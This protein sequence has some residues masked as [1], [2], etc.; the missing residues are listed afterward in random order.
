MIPEPAARRYAE[1]AHLIAKEQSREDEW[2]DS[3]RAIA[4][5]FDNADA[6][7]FFANS[8][9]PVD[10]KNKL[11]ENSL[12]G[13]STDIVNFARLLLRR[14]RTRLA[15][16]IAQAY[17]ELLDKE[18]GVVHATV[19]SAVPLSDDELRETTRK[20]EEMT[21]GRV[22]V[23]TEVNESILGGLVVRIGDRLIDGSTRSKLLALKQRLSG[24]T[25]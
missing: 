10:A 25:A 23:E 12:S 17:Q 2:A 21:G 3:L 18:K 14:Q 6:A 19:I 13:L 24:A 22:I 11:L 16:Q 5:L 15:P 8:G 20:I 9:I 4:A 1:A 7:R